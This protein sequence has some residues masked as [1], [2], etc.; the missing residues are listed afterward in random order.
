VNTGIAVA[1]GYV[2]FGCLRVQGNVGATV[3]GVSAHE[4]RRLA[5]DAQ[6]EDDGAVK[7]ALAHG[8]VAVVGQIDAVVGPHRDAVSPRVDTLAPG[9]EEITV[10]FEDD[11]RVLAPVENVYVFLGV[12]SDCGA[13]FVRP[14]VGERAP[15]FFYLISEGA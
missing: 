2:E 4:G 12:N 1:V 5:A 8:V 15:T 7:F 14:T 3:E 9:A 10:L 6:G 11:H 13:L